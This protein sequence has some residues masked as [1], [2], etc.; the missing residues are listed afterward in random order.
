[1]PNDRRRAVFYAQQNEEKHSVTYCTIMRYSVFLS[2]L[3]ERLLRMTIF[4]TADFFLFLRNA[5]KTCIEHGFTPFLFPMRRYSL[6]KFDRKSRKNN[7]KFL[8][9]FILNGV[10]LIL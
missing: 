3:I 9:L 1:L 10:R 5:V 2:V 8:I 4:L 7:R 6:W